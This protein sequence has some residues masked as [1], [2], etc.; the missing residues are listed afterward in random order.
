MKKESRFLILLQGHFHL[1][2]VKQNKTVTKNLEGFSFHK[3]R[4]KHEVQISCFLEV[5]SKYQ[6][7]AKNWE[8][9]DTQ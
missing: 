9:N 4:F 7:L 1:K 6:L 8:R 5:K 2:I 3:E